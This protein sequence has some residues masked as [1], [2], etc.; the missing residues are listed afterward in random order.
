MTETQA[1]EVP[2][3]TGPK[4]PITPER[5]RYLRDYI[6]PVRNEVKK[7]LSSQRKAKDTVMFK[8]LLP[9][10]TEGQNPHEMSSAQ[11]AGVLEENKKKYFDW[12]N[13]HDM[14]RYGL[15]KQ[16]EAEK[17]P[18][19][20]LLNKVG[21]ER[22]IKQ[23]IARYLREKKGRAIAKEE[24]ISPPCIVYMDANDLKLVNDLYGHDEGDEFL[25]EFARIIA[26]SGRE[27]VDSP[28][29]LSGDEY[30]MLLPRTD[31]QGTRIWF[32]KLKQELDAKGLSLSAGVI[33]LD[34]NNWTQS[35][36]EADSAMQIAKAL[37]KE[38]KATAASIRKQME[39][40]ADPVLKQEMEETA[41]ALEK[42]GHENR[43]LS[44]QE[45]RAI[46]EA[47]PNIRD[48]LKGRI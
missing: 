34:P 21:F 36:H 5:I 30:A 35:I 1:P 26:A 8:D 24:D 41:K 18:L 10:M 9:V 46:E 29:H 7:I 31:I 22:R 47:Q 32:A 38:S 4:N 15:A 37:G 28:A 42:H 12:E 27:D 48:Y 23:E 17:N 16:E 3:K 6:T 2:Q 19:S 40:E 39:E 43:M 44:Y 45:A 25:R 11:V 14:L 13:F 33:Q 20:G